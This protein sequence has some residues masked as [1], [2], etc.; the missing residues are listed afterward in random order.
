MSHQAVKRALQRG[1]LSVQRAQWAAAA[2]A[3]AA[4]SAPAK[5]VEHANKKD[6]DALR[7]DAIES[8]RK[9]SEHAAWQSAR[10]A[11]REQRHNAVLERK[12]KRDAAAVVRRAEVISR[13]VSRV[14]GEVGWEGELAAAQKA[15][16]D[17]AVFAVR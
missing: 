9:A 4:A 6:A 2:A 16:G 13:A 7:L 8:A 1:A 15:G 11:E 12:T 5:T 3:D 10:T 14:A 17:E